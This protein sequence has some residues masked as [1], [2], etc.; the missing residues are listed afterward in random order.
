[1]STWLRSR[2]GSAEKRVAECSQGEVSLGHTSSFSLGSHPP[3]ER[4]VTSKTRMASALCPYSPGT[5]W[6]SMGMAMM[7]RTPLK[8]TFRQPVPRRKGLT[9]RLPAGT[10][11][12]RP[13][14]P[15][16]VSPSRGE[17]EQSGRLGQG[18]CESALPLAPRRWEKQE[19][20][21]QRS[22]PPSTPA[23]GRPPSPL[24]VPR[25]SHLIHGDGNTFFLGLCKFS[26][27]MCRLAGLLQGAWTSS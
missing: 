23:P 7:G 5:E 11:C 1:M 25:F 15:C 24:R 18:S 17:S 26:E 16:H 14:G 20:L 21:T 13:G 6:L 19:A 8:E 12:P 9:Q 3:T 10:R 27:I 4:M 2:P 22:P